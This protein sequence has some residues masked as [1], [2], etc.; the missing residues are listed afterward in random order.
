MYNWIAA[1]AAMTACFWISSFKSSFCCLPYCARINQKVAEA[2]MQVTIDL[3]DEQTKRLFKQ[4]L[5]EM[6][7][8][9]DQALYELIAEVLEDLAM[10]RAIQKGRESE[11][12]AREEIFQIL[13]GAS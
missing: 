12:V 3:D 11:L 1:Y 13:E 5:V 6:I 2:G 8:A 7:E 4:S 10:G 9:R